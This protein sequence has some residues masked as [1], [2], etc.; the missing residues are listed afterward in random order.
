MESEG[1][2]ELCQKQLLNNCWLKMSGKMNIRSISG[3]R[4]KPMPLKCAAQLIQNKIT[5]KATINKTQSFKVENLFGDKHDTKVLEDKLGEDNG[6][7]KVGIRPE[8]LSL[9]F[10]YWDY[11]KEYDKDSLGVLRISCRV[12][13]LGSPDGSQFVKVWLSEKHLAPLKVQ[14]FDQK[15]LKSEKPLQVLTFED[16]AEKNKVWVPLEVKIT[17]L[18]GDLQ[19]KFDE[20]D[21]EF[22]TK[23]P[24]DLYNTEN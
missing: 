13:L 15:S 16:F 22:S 17:N 5:F 8:D 2:L 4:Q 24:A 11:L 20:V 6:F 21:A 1:F 18:K 3:K 23:I 7:D 10:M 14:W 12:L 19:I 9:S